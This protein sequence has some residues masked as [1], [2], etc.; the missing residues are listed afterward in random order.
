MRSHNS[1]SKYETVAATAM[2][3]RSLTPMEICYTTKTTT[4]DSTKLYKS[5]LKSCSSLAGPSPK[6]ILNLVFF[7]LFDK[8][9]NDLKCTWSWSGVI[10]IIS[11]VEAC[12]VVVQSIVTVSG[13]GVV[14]QSIVTIG[15]EW[16]KY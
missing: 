1:S 9:L 2:D 10:S 15:G 11:L 16:G 4:L 3:N 6:Y 12:G 14:V 5:I 8:H 7:N 13:V